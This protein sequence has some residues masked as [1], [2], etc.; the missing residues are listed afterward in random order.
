MSDQIPEH[1]SP[2]EPHH[3]GIGEE[4]NPTPMWF[5]VSW[6]GTWI[7]GACYIVYYLLIS[8]WSSH[9]QWEEQ[10]AAAEVKRAEV[11]AQLPSAN[12][13]R[14]DAGAIAEGKESFDTICASCHL[15]NGQGLVGPSLIDPYWKYGH[16]DAALFQTVSEGRPGGMPPWGPQLGNDRIWK[17]LAYME[18]LPKTDEP[19]LGA[20]DGPAVPGAAGA[21]GG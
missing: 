17:I 5:N 15:P 19:G 11:V 14:G 16:D 7:F 6:I 2:G 20:P 3:D 12:P 9:G 21:S 13:Y 10:A 1:V 18:T 8:D 4:N